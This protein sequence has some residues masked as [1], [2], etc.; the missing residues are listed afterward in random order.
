MCETA[1]S[2]VTNV[3]NLFFIFIL[4]NAASER[5]LHPLHQDSHQKNRIS[6]KF[7]YD[8]KKIP[9][10]IPILKFLI[11]TV[12]LKIFGSFAPPPGARKN[13]P[14][15]HGNRKNNP[16]GR[17][18]F[19]HDP[20]GGVDSFPSPLGWCRFVSKPLG[21]K[22]LFVPAAHFDVNAFPGR[23]TEYLVFSNRARK[24]VF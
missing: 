18:K 15:G 13:H 21:E 16:T 2:K 8:K 3:T 9:K 14:P 24:R 7:P 17:K 19:F 5:P 20:G 11:L 23:G 10:K 6:K 22:R 4:V 1:F 12:P